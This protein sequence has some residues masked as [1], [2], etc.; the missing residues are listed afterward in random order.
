VPEF[1]RFDG[2]ILRI[3]QL[4]DQQYVE[5]ETS[6]TFPTVPKEWLYDFLADCRQD[7]LAAE[8]KLRDRL[9]QHLA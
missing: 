1:W 7:E 8:D 6:P 9:H 3:Y 4:Q 2:H 5:V